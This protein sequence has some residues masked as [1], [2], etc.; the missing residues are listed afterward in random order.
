MKKTVTHM[1]FKN[2]RK[3]IYVVELTLADNHVVIVNVFNDSPML[4]KKG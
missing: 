1:A 3:N 4:A 2:S